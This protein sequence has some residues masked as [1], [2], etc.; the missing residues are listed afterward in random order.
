M[1]NKTDLILD[2]IQFTVH[3]GRQAKRTST[4][5]TYTLQ[6]FEKKILGAKRAYHRRGGEGA[7][8]KII[9]KLGPEC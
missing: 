9:F 5:L 4:P 7:L 2:F 8:S 1:V 6:S 3:R